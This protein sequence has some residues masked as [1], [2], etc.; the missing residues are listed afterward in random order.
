[1]EAKL[2]S[3]QLRDRLVDEHCLLL[4]IQYNYERQKLDRKGVPI[5]NSRIGAVSIMNVIIIT[6]IS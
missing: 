3:K 2:R 5:S 1:M 4:W 6:S